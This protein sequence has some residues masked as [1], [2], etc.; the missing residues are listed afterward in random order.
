ME[1]EQQVSCMGTWT[2]GPFTYSVIRHPSESRAWCMRFSA[3]DGKKS[4]FHAVLFR[5]LFCDREARS[6]RSESGI[7]FDMKPEVG[8]LLSSGQLCADDYE[9]CSW[10]NPCNAAGSMRS[11]CARLC[12]VCNDTVP[13]ICS[14][15][16]VLRGNWNDENE[17]SKI[18][19]VNITRSTV[20]INGIGYKC[21]D[22]KPRSSVHGTRT[23]RSAGMVELMLVTSYSNGCRPRYRCGQ[24]KRQ[25][26]TTLRY[27]LSQKQIWPIDG[28]SEPGP[29]SI[30]CD[31]FRYKPKTH[32]LQQ[33]QQQHH[34]QL[35]KH[36]WSDAAAATYHF[37]ALSIIEEE[38]EE[39]EEAEDRS[40]SITRGRDC[41]IDRTRRGKFVFSSG[42]VCDG[43]LLA[44]EIDPSRMLLSV[45]QDCLA[46]IS[47]PFFGSNASHICLDHSSHPDHHSP[48]FVTVST[49]TSDES[50]KAFCWIFRQFD[51]LLHF[52][53]KIQ[54]QCQHLS[55]IPKERYSSGGPFHRKYRYYVCTRKS[56]GAKRLE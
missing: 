21:V 18:G 47:S 27:R 2:D 25:N 3:R 45:D 38:E 39:E 24:F 23:R 26:S 55:P 31:L 50:K 37:K 48:P 34:Q 33:K 20:A 36:Q 44:N 12:G 1:R 19:I 13:A 35:Y 54:L 43:A 28:S 5:D 56:T 16:E 7:V 40:D 30:G 11:A 32:H 8:H 10:E 14:V 6:T 46:V 49:V 42:V 17:I 15:P 52:P 22:W 53:F 9:A 51:S 4:Q 41:L 29:S